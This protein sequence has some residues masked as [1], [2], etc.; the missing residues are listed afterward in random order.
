VL[1]SL[2]LDGITSRIDALEF[3]DFDLPEIESFK[4][5]MLAEGGK[6]MKCGIRPSFDEKREKIVF[7]GDSLLLLIPNINDVWSFRLQARI[8]SIAVN[9]RAVLLFPWEEILYDDPIPNVRK[10]IKLP[11]AL[12]ETIQN[13]RDA[14]LS[15]LPAGG[16][17]SS[18]K[19][20]VM[21]NKNIFLELEP[22]FMLDI[23]F[24]MERVEDLMVT[25]IQTLILQQ[26]PLEPAT[27]P[28]YEATILKMNKIKGSALCLALGA[29]AEGELDGAIGLVSQLADGISPTAAEVAKYSKFFKSLLKRCEQFLALRVHADDA[30]LSL[31][32]TCYAPGL[33]MGRSALEYKVAAYAADVEKGLPKKMIDA[34]DFRRFKWLLSPDVKGKVDEWIGAAMKSHLSLPLVPSL[35]DAKKPSSVGDILHGESSSSSSSSTSIVLA[36]P[37]AKGVKATDKKT[38]KHQDVKDASKSNI[39]KFFMKA[40]T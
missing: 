2:Y 29:T 9:V 22:T 32:M 10:E 24:L 1:R 14:V 8:K 25:K 11:P 38:P 40:K 20:T 27:E 37:G 7:L 21:A 34:M 6:V 3:H 23:T 26:F 4:K 35:E 5:I 19:K 39:M 31:S 30:L 17:L 28:A 36:S 16:T 15:L 18:W 12:V 33:L 13:C